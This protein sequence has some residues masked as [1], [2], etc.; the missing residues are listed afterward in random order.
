MVGR[1]LAKL[2]IEGDGYFVDDRLPDFIL[3]FLAT[4]N[5]HSLSSLPRALAAYAQCDPARAESLRRHLHVSTDQYAE[6]L[7]IAPPAHVAKWHLL[8]AS[9]PWCK[10][11]ARARAARPAGAA[12]ADE[13]PA[14]GCECADALVDAEKEGLALRIVKTELYE[15][16]SAHLRALKDGFNG[17]G[18]DEGCRPFEMSAHLNMFS[19]TE[20]ALR[21]RGRRVDDGAAAWAELSLRRQEVDD[22]QGSD[23]AEAMVFAVGE[24]TFEAVRGWFRSEV[25]AMEAEKVRGLMRMITG[26]AAVRNS[27]EREPIAVIVYHD[28]ESRLPTASTCLRTMYLPAYESHALLRKKLH[29]AL[30]EF[31]AGDAR[32]GGA[33]FGYQ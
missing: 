13:P 19:P 23:K 24:D 28:P 25:L 5:V 1:L 11:C 20:L 9:L 21:L 18:L 7:C 10:N 17:H 4:D 29:A 12:E 16:R 15:C 6:Y 27:E 3:E 2:L 30:D 22:A 26:I 33:G 8:G 14:S 32:D 31:I